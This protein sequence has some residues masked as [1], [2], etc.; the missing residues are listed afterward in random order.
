MPTVPYP[1]NPF[2]P[3]PESVVAAMDGA[4]ELLRLKNLLSHPVVGYGSLTGRIAAGGV[5]GFSLTDHYLS[6]FDEGAKDISAKM[7]PASRAMF[8]EIAVD[9]RNGFAAGLAQHEAEQKQAL[10]SRASLEAATP[11]RTVDRHNTSYRGAQTDVTPSDYSSELFGRRVVEPVVKYQLSEHRVSDAR[12]FF[13]AY[14]GN[15]A[16]DDAQ[17]LEATLIAAEGAAAAHPSFRI[18][19]EVQEILGAQPKDILPRTTSA[20][21]SEPVTV[22]FGE[23]PR[24]I[25]G[26]AVPEPTN[27][28][29]PYSQ[30]APPQQSPL[31]E[32]R[33][34]S[35]DVSDLEAEDAVEAER[36]ETLGRQI[37]KTAWWL[38]RRSPWILA[39]AGLAAPSKIGS[40]QKTYLFGT[41]G[42]FAQLRLTKDIGDV[43]PE[44]Q[45]RRNGAW[46]SLGK[47]QPDFHNTQIFRIDDPKVFFQR[48]GQNWNAIIVQ[49]ADRKSTTKVGFGISVSND[50]ERQVLNDGIFH[51]KDAREI[52]NHLDILRGNTPGGPFLFKG[53]PYKPPVAPQPRE[54]Q[55]GSSTSKNYR[56][57]FFGAHPQL[58]RQVVVH[59]A[60]ERQIMTLYP[61]L[62]SEAELH[63]LEN[64]RGIPKDINSSLHLSTLRKEMNV[65]YKNHPNAT[66][67]DVLDEATRL[68]RKYGHLFK[69]SVGEK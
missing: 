68:D 3:S 48:T 63:S 44:L 29:Q 27:S 53:P 69:P 9:L 35:Q 43:I 55:V 15:M 25:D 19:P 64:L 67:Q 49:P 20:F 40:E 45:V 59:H 38:A 4:N 5:P 37:G 23:M 21:S 1:Q 57:T 22:P 10:R 31:G 30:S 66:R 54:A 13:D 26:P 42:R 12:A 41:D 2:E 24:P 56:G 18:S 61:Q 36:K 16:A 6:V 52:Q 58:K 14:S 34:V 28:P 7:R 17:T 32:F 60:I 50:A 39:A 51:R 65:F 33:D 8:N 47:L 11:T 62:F 46:Q